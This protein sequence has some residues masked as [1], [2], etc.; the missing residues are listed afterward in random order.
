[1]KITRFLPIIVLV[2]GMSACN[3]PA[4]QLV[5]ASIDGPM[6]DVAPL[7][8]KFIRQGSFLMGANEQSVV[9]AQSDNNIKVSVN[10]FWMDETE[11]TNNE[12]RQFVYWV[13]DSIARSLLIDQQYDEFGRLNDTTKK[14]VINWA[15]PI[16]W[17][18]RQNPNAQLDVT[19]LDSLFYDNGLGGLNISKLRYNYSWSNTGAAIDREK[20]FDVAKGVYPEGT[21]IEVDTFYIDANGLIKRE[22][23]KRRLREPKD[24]LT[25]AIICIYPDT[26]VWARDFDYSYNDPL[27]HGYFSMPSYAEY[28]VVGVTWE[29]AHAFC[30]WRTQLLRTEG[31]QLI[32]P[33][34]LPSEAEWEFAARGGLK[35]AM[36]PWGNKSTRDAKGCFL[37]NFKPYRGSYHND[38]GST[39]MAVGG[40]EPNDFGLFDMAGNVAEWTATSFSSKSN[41]NIHDMNPEY[42][43]MA[44][45][46]DP[47]VLKRK[48]VKGG[49]WKDISY[50]LQCGVRSYE[51]QYESR[52]YIGFRCVRSAMGKQYSK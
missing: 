36:Y 41:T 27:L 38:T 35:A 9:F 6:G 21:M 44:R 47:G 30:H 19:V 22:T 14:Y 8:M 33:Y 37:A 25:N 5:G 17:I 48:V 23:V 45:E 49:S 26:M 40:F 20:R 51:Y 11:I 32:L 50:Y 1:M 4:G 39:T 18:D 2:L 29:Q 3:N 12:Y 15:K 43:Y 7:G 16:P 52:S 24:L 42:T 10:A 34:R 28:P 13:R 46:N 31:K